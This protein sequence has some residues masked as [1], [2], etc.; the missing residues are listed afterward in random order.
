M[1]RRMEPRPTRPLRGIA[2]K[3]ASVLIFIVMA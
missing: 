2:L 3:L 1:H